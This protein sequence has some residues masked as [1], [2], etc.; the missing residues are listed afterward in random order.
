MICASLGFNIDFAD[1]CS[2]NSQEH[3]NIARYPYRML[4]PYLRTP[5]NSPIYKHRRA[6]LRG[7]MYENLIYERLLAWARSANGVSESVMSIVQTVEQTE[8]VPLEEGKRH[9]GEVAIWHRS[10][11]PELP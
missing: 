8:D 4:K 2:G 6:N 3:A 11:R 7:E 5:K 9:D 10:G 1:R